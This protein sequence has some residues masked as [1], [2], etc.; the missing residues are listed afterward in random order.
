MGVR[1]DST[2]DDASAEM[3]DT[4]LR[5]KWRNGKGSD[6]R[7]SCFFKALDTWRSVINTV[8]LVT[9]LVL[10]LVRQDVNKP[11]KK[12]IGGDLAGFAPKCESC[13][14]VRIWSGALS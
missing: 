9:I 2:D 3:N 5:T 1:R 8:L 12:E 14:Y 10:L 11:E 6:E 7:R 4:L 13:P